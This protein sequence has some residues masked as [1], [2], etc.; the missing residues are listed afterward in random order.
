MDMLITFP[1]ENVIFQVTFGATSG[2]EMTHFTLLYIKHQV[3]NEQ[4]Q[5]LIHDKGNYFTNMYF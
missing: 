4:H 5:I 3:C 1:S 2:A